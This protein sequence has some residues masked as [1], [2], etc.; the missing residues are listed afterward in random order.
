V[1][2]LLN[3]GSALLLPNGLSVAFPGSQE[4]V[5]GRWI[6]I[7]IKLVKET[8][9]NITLMMDIKLNGRGKRFGENT[10]TLPYGVFE[11]GPPDNER[12]VIVRCKG[13]QFSQPQSKV[14]A[15]D[16]GR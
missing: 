15:K 12:V 16:G 3:C 1:A 11:L 8:T 10:N 13:S 9:K 5:K 14:I 7:L 2:T 4:G 6:D